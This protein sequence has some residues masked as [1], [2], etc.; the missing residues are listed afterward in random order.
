MAAAHAEL[1]AAAGELRGASLDERARAEREEFLRFQLKE[2]QEAELDPAADDGLKVERE[3]LRA[4]DRLLT[5]ARRG[6]D[7]L[8]AREGAIVEELGSIAHELLELGKI[9]PQLAPLGKQIDESRV[10]LEDAAGELRRYAE[11]LDADPE[12]LQ[13]I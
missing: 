3:R 9:D 4:A 2:L 11:G 5:A 8:Y 1:A 12:R 6:E 7:A 13:Q 10:L